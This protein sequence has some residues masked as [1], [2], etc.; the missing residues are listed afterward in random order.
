[1]GEY[2]LNKLNLMVCLS[3]IR[4]HKSTVIMH[5]D[6]PPAYYY[7]SKG[8]QVDLLSLAVKL[9]TFIEGCSLLLYSS[10]HCLQ[11]KWNLQVETVE[12]PTKTSW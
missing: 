12:G 8:N 9:I 10:N 7:T 1:M 2:K 5:A 3:K 4:S 11:R 6:Y